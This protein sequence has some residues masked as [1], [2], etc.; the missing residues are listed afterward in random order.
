MT[1]YGPIECCAMHIFCFFDLHEL[2]R[3]YQTLC[4]KIIHKTICYFIQDF[5]TNHFIYQK[6]LHTYISKQRIHTYPILELELFK[7]SFKIYLYM[8]L[9]KYKI[10]EGFFLI[11]KIGK[12]F[13][14]KKTKT[15]ILF[16]MQQQNNILYYR[17]NEELNEAG[18]GYLYKSNQ[19]VDIPLQ[20]KNDL[21]FSS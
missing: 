5:K 17:I 11:N 18:C 1:C 6:V 15:H 21:H 19:N 3:Q 7:T 9:Q 4:N 10:N 16:I 14:I 20:I 2:Q 8:L 12:C 13:F